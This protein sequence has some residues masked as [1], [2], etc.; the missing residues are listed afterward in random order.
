MATVIPTVALKKSRTS[1]LFLPALFITTQQVIKKG[2]VVDL[3][4]RVNQ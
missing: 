2:Q 1:G 3:S 4:E